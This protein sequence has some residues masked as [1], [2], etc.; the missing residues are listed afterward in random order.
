MRAAGLLLA[1]V[2]LAPAAARG[3]ASV[4]SAG[5]K[6][7]VTTK[8]EISGAGASK[9]VARRI[10]DGIAG[11]SPTKVGGYSLLGCCK[12]TTRSTVRVVR[13]SGRPRPGYN[14][15]Q[16]TNDPD[17]RSFVSGTLDGG[18][19]SSAETGEVYAHE[20]GHLLGLFDQYTDVTDDN[21]ES[22]SKTLPGHEMD[23]MGA[24]GGKLG[25]GLDARAALDRLLTGKGA[26]C[27]PRRC[28]RG[29]TTTTTLPDANAA[30]VEIAEV[31]CPEEQCSC[32]LPTPGRRWT[33]GATGTASGPVG[34][35]LTVSGYLTDLQCGG[36]TSDPIPDNGPSCVRSTVEQPVDIAWTAT[37]PYRGPVTE[38]YC[39][40]NPFQVSISASVDTADGL[41]HSDRDLTCP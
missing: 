4:Q 31:S 16:I 13:R 10:R 21:G 20:A 19:W 39:V 1:G 35:R 2:L 33:Y 30:R 37:G 23:K 6:T 25:V 5:C 40:S 34:S 28:C 7:F 11:C 9:A 12:V 14:Q 17:F 8:I 24:P 27:D 18:T 38:C 26:R 22:V 32:G 15:V 29:T 36:W 41:V 3:E